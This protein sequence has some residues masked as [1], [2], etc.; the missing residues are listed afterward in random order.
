MWEDSSL[1]SPLDTCAQCTAAC[2][3]PVAV[4]ALSVPRAYVCQPARTE[5]A[6]TASRLVSSS[7]RLIPGQPVAAEPV[8]TGPR[9]PRDRPRRHGV[10]CAA[11]DGRAARSPLPEQPI[12]AAG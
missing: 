12:T 7:P 5:S 10:R 4:T 2:C 6:D 9:A 1:S 11:R 8:M 3:E